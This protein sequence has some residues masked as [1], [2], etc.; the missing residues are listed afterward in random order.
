MAPAGRTPLPWTAPADFRM[1]SGAAPATTRLAACPLT[2]IF[3]KAAEA[4]P[5]SRPILA[6][7][8]VD[9]TAQNPQEIAMAAGYIALH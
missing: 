2:S 9:A 7:A 8:H 3:S 6:E 1:V 5:D 4:A